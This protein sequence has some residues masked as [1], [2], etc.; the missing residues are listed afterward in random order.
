MFGKSTHPHNPR[1]LADSDLFYNTDYWD[2]LEQ[3]V[4]SRQK[5]DIGKDSVARNS[6]KAANG[7]HLNYVFSRVS[8]LG[9]SD[10]SCT[11]KLFFLS[12]LATSYV[13]YKKI[14]GNL[15]PFPPFSPPGKYWS[16]LQEN[17]WKFSP[18]SLI[19]KLPG[20]IF[21]YVLQKYLAPGNP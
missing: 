11:K 20:K 17:F 8:L 12:P 5:K 1:N 21:M 6:T 13:F 18:L 19:L 7:K 16:V 3:E 9:K 2:I 15:W 10:V 14:F 4:K